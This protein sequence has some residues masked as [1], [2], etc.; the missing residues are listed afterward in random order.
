MALPRPLAEVSGL[1]TW[2]S[3]HLLAHGDELATLYVISASD[4][5]IVRPIRL[6]V[7]R[8]AGDYEDVALDG[9][10]GYLVQSD[11]TLFEFTL[12]DT[13]TVQAYHRYS[14]LLGGAC[15]VE[16]L[17]LD[18][19]GSGLVVACKRVRGLRR[20]VGV[21]FL[22]WSA[23]R[24]FDLH[25]AFTIPWRALGGDG[26]RARFAASGMVRT[27]DRSGWLVLDG[28]N[29]RIAEVAAGGRVVSL[30]ELP[31]DLLPQAEGITIGLDGTLYVA[32]EGKHGPGRLVAYAPRQASGW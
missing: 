24:Q 8:R 17:G 28:P 15:E 22:R 26:D 10:H 25:P 16:A 2:D 13:S 14:G 32:T 12:D 11:G 27:P 4:G 29:G 21:P 31:R 6:G 19:A 18:L 23:R 1:A 3:A 30:R 9:R 5:R 7:R 20:P